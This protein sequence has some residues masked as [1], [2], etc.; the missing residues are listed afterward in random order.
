MGEET[1]NI[2][3][4]LSDFDFLPIVFSPVTNRQEA[5]DVGHKIYELIRFYIISQSCLK[6]TYYEG[7]AHDAKTSIVSMDEYD[8]VEP[9]IFEELE[10]FNFPISKMLS[11]HGC[12]TL[13]DIASS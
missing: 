11:I 7:Y 3:T 12:K 10:K 6:V 5:K 1:Y 4:C 8:L 9:I 2:I 13:K